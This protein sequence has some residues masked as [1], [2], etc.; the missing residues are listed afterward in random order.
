M[1]VERDSNRASLAGIAELVGTIAAEEGFA[2][3]SGRSAESLRLRAALAFE[4]P[5]DRSQD[6]DRRAAVEVAAV[7]LLD[8]LRLELARDLPAARRL[9]ERLQDEAGVHPATLARGLLHSPDLLS[10]DPLQGLDAQF[11]AL[12]MLGPIEEVSLWAR[13]TEIGAELLRLAGAE[14][15]ADG[16]AEFAQEQLR[17]TSRRGATGDLFSA[18]MDHSDGVRALLVARADPELAGRIKSLLAEAVPAM[19]ATLERAEL[20]ARGDEVEQTLSASRDRRLARLGLDVHDGPLQDLA[21]LAQDLALFR[22]QI[23]I[24]LEGNPRATLMAGRLD[25]LEAQLVAIDA[26]LRR[27]AV[28]LQSPFMSHHDLERALREIVDVFALSTGVEPQVTLAGDLTTVSESQQLAVLSITREAL[29]NIR[30][31]AGAA[32]VTVTV[33]VDNLGLRAEIGDD[34]DGFDVE[35]TL[36]LA[37]RDGHLGLVGMQERVRMLDGRSRIDSAPGGPTT[38]TFEL[39]RF[40]RPE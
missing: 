18:R 36:I 21:A 16:I 39:P 15:P 4:W 20:I 19:V 23:G 37:A 22:S 10:M 2:R 11:S 25:D 24:T 30:E 14:V 31:H 9:I 6:R 38:F 3:P 29:N 40:T 34:G 7:E 26:D 33:M 28:S 17:A 13:D 35:S 27:L 1:Q 32:K 5:H 8:Q 12:M